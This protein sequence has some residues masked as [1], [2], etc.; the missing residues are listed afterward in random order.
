MSQLTKSAEC[1]L[2]VHNIVKASLEISERRKNVLIRHL[3]CIFVECIECRFCASF[4]YLDRL[5]S[6]VIHK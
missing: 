3:F 2:A 6:K 5:T 1:Q 4:N